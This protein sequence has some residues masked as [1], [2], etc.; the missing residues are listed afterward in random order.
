MPTITGAP[1]IIVAGSPGA[2]SNPVTVIDS[3]ASH[4]VGTRITIASGDDDEEFVYLTGVAS[5]VAGSCVT[6][7]EAGITTLI[8]ANA[9]GPVAF[10]MAAT[11]ASTFGWYKVRGVISASCDAG[12]VD[13]SKV[14]IDGTAG[15]VDDTVVAGDQLTNAV[16]RS[17]DTSNFAS[18]QFNN[19]WAT[20]SLG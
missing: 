10:A 1:G 17:T 19:P 12:I 11:V 2:G 18:V 5:T 3:V 16:F 15:R 9:I 8:V 13:N 6:F 20:D 4:P 14:Y 7:D